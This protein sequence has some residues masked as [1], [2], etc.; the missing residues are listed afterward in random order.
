MTSNTE[1]HNSMHCMQVLRAPKLTRL[2]LDVRASFHYV[3]PDG[4]DQ[5]PN[6]PFLAP[7]LQSLE[8]VMMEHAPDLTGVL[9]ATLTSLVLRQWLRGRTNIVPELQCLSSYC[10]NLQLVVSQGCNLDHFESVLDPFKSLSRWHP[11]ITWTVHANIPIRLKSSM[12]LK[13]DAFI[14]ECSIW[15]CTKTTYRIQPILFNLYVVLD[16]VSFKITCRR[17]D[18]GRSSSAISVGQNHANHWAFFHYG[19]G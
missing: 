9:A 14:S 4:S 17:R 19:E 12:A 11:L 13:L 16:P 6:I 3:C 1:F 18:D 2:R 7:N 5:L 10:P 15:M 8:V